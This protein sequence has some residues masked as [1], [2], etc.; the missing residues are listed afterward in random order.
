MG[1]DDN[2]S[3][4]GGAASDWAGNIMAS[5]DGKPDGRNISGIIQA[6]PSTRGTA[7]EMGNKWALPS[8]TGNSEITRSGGK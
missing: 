8:M 3:D 7:R 2:Y 1:L 5:R 4:S 6:N